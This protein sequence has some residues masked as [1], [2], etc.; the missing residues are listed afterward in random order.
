[1]EKYNEMINDMES[2]VRNFF[3]HFTD[4]PEYLSG[5]G[6]N[7]FCEIDG[8]KLIF[9]LNQPKAH[10]CEICNHL[11]TG[12]KYD[13][14][15]IY[16]NRLQSF[17]EI[18]KSAYLFQQTKNQDYLGFAID[19]LLY[20]ANNY[21]DFVLHAKD[22][23]IS[24]EL[25]IDVGGAGKIMPQGLNEAYMLIKI[26]QALEILSTDIKSA[27][28][29]TIKEKLITPAIEDVLVPQLIRI[30]NIQCWI[31]CAIAAAGFY[32]DNQKWIDYALVGDFKIAN[33]LKNGVTKD[34]LWYEG[35]I[36]YHFFM[37]ESILNLLVYPKALKYLEKEKQIVKS[38]LKSAYQ[39]AFDNNV[40]PNPNDGWPNISLKTY[41]H[42]Y[43]MAVKVFGG[44][45]EV[46]KMIKAIEES[47]IKRMP[48]QLADPYYFKDWPLEKLLF[49]SEAV[50]CAK[51]MKRKSYLFEDSNFAMLRNDRVNLFMKF[52]HNGPSHAHPDKMTFELTLDDKLITRDLSNAG[53]GADICNEWHRVSA[54]HN[55]IVVDGQNQT[56]VEAGNVL[57]FNQNLIKAEC[58]DVYPGINFSRQFE[59][60]DSKITDEFCVT[61]NE[62]HT[63]D[64][65]IHIDGL[66][67]ID[68]SL[69]QDSPLG[70]EENGYEH[71]KNV[72]I[73]NGLKDFRVVVDS[74][75]LN[76][77]I[78]TDC[79]IFICETLDNPVTRCRETIILR[80][81]GNS[82]TFNVTWKF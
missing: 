12:S 71:I 65:F 59:L 56:N 16:L 7:Y 25:T 66:I 50:D 76:L 6:H 27:D 2:S 53:Y 77:K 72:K 62:A 68:K 74:V 30:H 20:Y 48:T 46:L 82:A 61:S 13:N 34:Y 39:Y 70:F 43:H 3:N 21:H 4:K 79:E 75:V 14:A 32:F 26:I 63:Y 45:H 51:E 18:V 36:H 78:E 73:V 52:G 29:E 35:S 23:I 47:N 40:F 10:K 5:W 28:V 31:G 55:T 54:S 67:D 1:M 49:N 80:K 44:C 9:E 81:K 15:W 24:T 17:T 69:F 42:T 64:C 19:A 37:L 60:S 58:K 11:Y 22:T 38:M 33:Q 41:L 8:G 57:S